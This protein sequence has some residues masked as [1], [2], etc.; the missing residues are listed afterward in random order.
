MACASGKS[1][2]T[3]SLLIELGADT[4]ATTAHDSSI[5]H[6]ACL[7]GHD[8]IVKQLAHTYALEIKANT[9]GYH[10]VHYA[11][12]C[13]RGA[14]CLE[15][16]VAGMGVDVNVRSCVDGRTP[17]HMAA[18]HGRT[19]CAQ[20]LLSNG[21][22]VNVQDVESNTPLHLAARNGHTPLMS[23]LIDFDDNIYM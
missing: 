2:E 16:L 18:L 15:L 10:P 8:Q 19:S 5:F 13:K 17:L 12:G 1:E 22:H 23:M 11:A 20:V 21:A 14:L 7:N 4:S 6:L 3:I 9:R